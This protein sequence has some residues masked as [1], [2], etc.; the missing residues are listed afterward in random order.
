MLRNEGLGLHRRSV[1]I[2][3]FSNR[4]A[5]EIFDVLATEF[6]RNNVA[7]HEKIV[8]L[9]SGKE[10]R[11]RDRQ[12]AVE[13]SRINIA[14]VW[15]AKGYDADTV[16]VINPDGCKGTPYEKRTQFYVAATR[17]KQFLAVY[18]SMPERQAPIVYDA[19][20][21]MK[22]LKNYKNS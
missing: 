19:I 17:A 3:C 10:I 6:N 15:D 8:H 21:A 4:T 16:Y 22:Q 20:K 7:N 2:Q 9:R 5:K 14:N 12:L 13:V 11:N 18:S 1:L